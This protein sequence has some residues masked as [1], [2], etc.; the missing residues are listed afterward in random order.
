MNR[1]MNRRGSWTLIEIVVVMLILLG[2][3]AW[4]LPRYA[5]RSPQP[6]ANAPATPVER[7]SGVECE[8]QLRQIRQAMQL[9]QVDHEEK[10]PA[11][12]SELASYGITSE[13][14]LSCPLGREPY[15]YDASSGQ[16]QCAHPGH[17][18]F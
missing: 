12:L 14:M 7:A 5:G 9:Y 10:F 11:S 17:E 4:L 18:R 3:A 6:G 2:L 15:R 1:L 13:A 8:N 16:A